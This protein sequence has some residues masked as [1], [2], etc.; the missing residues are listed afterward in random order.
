[1]PLAAPAAIVVALVALLVLLAFR[2]LTQWLARNFNFS[3]GVGSFSFNLFGFINNIVED[4]YSGLVSIMDALVQPIESLILAP[5]NAFEQLVDSIWGSIQ[6]L[7]NTL[8]A[9]SE[10]TIPTAV[11]NSLTILTQFAGDVIVLQDEAAASAG[12]S[13]DKDLADINSAIAN[14]LSTAESYTDSKFTALEQ[15][16][17]SGAL[18][19]DAIASLVN[20]AVSAALATGLGPLESDL[21][22]V[23]N[24]ATSYAGGLFSTAERDIAAALST[25][26]GFATTAIN[27]ATGILTTDIDQLISQAYAPIATD[28]DTAVAGAIGAAGD[29][30]IDIVSA[31][32]S[33]PLGAIASIAGVTALAGTTALTLARFLEEC[34]IPNCTNLSQYGKDLQ[35][36]LGV[37][38]DA[39]FLEFIVELAQH[40]SEADSVVQSTF[41]DVFTTTTSAF[42]SLIGV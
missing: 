29:I 19:P 40:P 21:Q 15:L 42:R 8:A 10:I 41:G 28:V 4:A 27:G 30:D 20:N 17:G 12:L 6:S 9:L 24:Q 32:K 18:N 38:N 22:T 14:T 35:A 39:S 37:V 13:L 16:I 33:I 31:L 36:I 34:G 2:A 11:L 5:V 26:E 25:A 3:V 23:Y 7:A 1:M